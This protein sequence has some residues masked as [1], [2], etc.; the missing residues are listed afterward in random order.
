MRKA[1][2]QGGERPRQGARGLGLVHSDLH[3]NNVLFVGEQARPIDF[4]DVG[5][6]YYLLDLAVA[7]LGFDP[8]GDDR[9]WQDALV[10]GYRS[11]RP[12]SDE[13]LDYL[14]LFMA[15]RQTTLLLW[16]RTCARDRPDFRKTLPRW[17]E[18]F[19]PDMRARL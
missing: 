2:R 5:E 7:V 14:D 16:C 12:I 17:R 10:A 15:A 11:A 8:P 6:S 1:A 9:P 3:F 18:R 13:L 4:D 19:L